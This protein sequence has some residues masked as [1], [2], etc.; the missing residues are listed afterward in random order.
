MKILVTG[1]AG[2][3]GSEL[4]GAPAAGDEIV[5]LTRGELEVTDAGGVARVMADVRPDAVINCAAYNAVDQAEEEPEVATAV[6]ARAV[7]HLAA[8]CRGVGAQLVHVS[9]DYVFGGS[10]TRPYVE[11][12]LPRPLSAYARSKLEGEVAARAAGSWAVVRT[13]YVFG[14]VGRSLVETILRRALAGEPLSMVTD[15][16]GS[17]TYAADLAGV[18]LRV[19]RERA[20]GTF[21]VVNGGDAS[22]YELARAV[23]DV[24]GVEAD[25]DTTTLADLRR[26]ALRPLFSVL[27]SERLETVG[28]APLRHH[29]EALEELVPQLAA[30]GKTP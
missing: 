1:A 28:I 13:A 22:P 23:L 15:Q 6:N 29:R 2:Q 17:P 25:L 30:A 5:A 24:A 7:E 4:V 26:P 3:V 16:R 10:Q 12:D 14:R 9:T 8:A 19:A 27:A 20:E 11:S 21:H 18:L